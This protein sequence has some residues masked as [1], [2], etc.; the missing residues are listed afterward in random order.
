MEQLTEQ[1]SARIA[2]LPGDYR[3]VGLDRG[4]RIL[5]AV[6]GDLLRVGGDDGSRNP[7]AL[8]RG[9]DRPGE[10]GLA[11]RRRQVLARDPLR[12]PSGGDQADDVHQ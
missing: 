9:L 7:P 12:A 5:A 2:E 10:K 1:Q 6:G 8:E 3:V 11:G 4:L